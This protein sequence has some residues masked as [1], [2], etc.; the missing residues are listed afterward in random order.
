MISRRAF[1]KSA[2]AAAVGFPLVA[3]QALARSYRVSAVSAANP[4]IDLRLAVVLAGFCEATY[5]QFDTPPAFKV[6]AG[7]TLV[8]RFTG[9][10]QQ[11]VTAPYGFIAESPGAVVIAFRGTRSG[12]EWITDS[13]FGYTAYPF[14]AEAGF[15]HAGFT[16]IYAT[17]R[18]QIIPVLRTLSAAKRLYV[19]GHSLGA[20]LAT[21]H[22]L[23][24]AVNTQFRSPTMYNFAS[25]RVGN[26]Q[27]AARYDRAIRSSIRII[28]SAD[29]VP[30][31]PSTTTGYTH[32]QAPWTFTAQMGSRGGNH[33]L[34]TYAAGVRR[35]LSR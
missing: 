35:A 25:P 20:A 30:M 24:A 19:T 22:A 26:R 1:L 6:P 8:A 28:N 21:L 4:P 5:V 27:F 11:K 32:V 18:E 12:T 7:Y 23:D 33:A 13:D 2:V 34:T 3:G 29:I 9:Q 17:T 16:G 15:T 10:D 31:L 14:V